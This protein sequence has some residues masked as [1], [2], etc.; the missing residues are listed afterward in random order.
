MTAAQGA[1]F[2]LS[3]GEFHGFCK[4]DQLLVYESRSKDHQ[5]KPIATVVITK[6]L[7]DTSIL[8]LAAGSTL[9]L[10]KYPNAV[11]VLSK[12]AMRFL[13]VHID[14]KESTL[15]HRID[16]LELCIMTGVRDDAHIAIS[17]HS[18]KQQLR[19]DIVDKDLLGMKD[20]KDSLKPRFVD[21]TDEDLDH[22]IKGLSHYYYHLK[23]TSDSLKGSI[24][25]VSV[26]F[27]QVRDTGRGYPRV[28]KVDGAENLCR[29]N[30]IDIDVTANPDAIYGFEITNNTDKGEI[31]YPVLFYFD[32]TD[33]TIG[34]LQRSNFLCLLAV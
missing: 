26:S 4:G 27:F 32:N 18:A 6:V 34:K 25:K 12:T 5:E 16:A 28:V 22:V 33:F 17:S 24:D 10:K 29:N 15:L 23:R 8:K 3:G 7:G 21:D 20:V 31:L 9:S 19:I 1:S 11:A 2:T 30:V 14:Q 13:K